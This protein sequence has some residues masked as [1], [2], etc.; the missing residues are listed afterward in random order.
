MSS[1][2]HTYLITGTTLPFESV[3]KPHFMSST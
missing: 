2:H 1:W 3:T